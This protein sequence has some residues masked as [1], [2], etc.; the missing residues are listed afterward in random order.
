[1]HNQNS[2]CAAY[3]VETGLIAHIIFAIWILLLI[4]IMLH[5]RNKKK[6]RNNGSFLE[7]NCIFSFKLIEHL[8]Y[9]FVDKFIC[10]RYFIS[11][12]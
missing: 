1:M 5:C 7:N 2:N 4:A 3:A 11:Q 10:K 8:M 9:A 6:E 12:S